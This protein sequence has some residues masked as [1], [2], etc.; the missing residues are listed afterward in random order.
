MI[1]KGK[2]YEPLAQTDLVKEVSVHDFLRANLQV[3]PYPCLSNQ[4]AINFQL[5]IGSWQLP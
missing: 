3:Q 2:E 5:F 4:R 1:S